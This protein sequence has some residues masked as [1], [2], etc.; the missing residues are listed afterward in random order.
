MQVNSDRLASQVL[1]SIAMRVRIRKCCDTCS[2][3]GVVAI[4][5][6]SCVKENPRS[7]LPGIGFLI[8]MLLGFGAAFGARRVAAIYLGLSDSPSGAIGVVCAIA[9]TMLF[10]WV[11]PLR[12]LICS[13]CRKVKAVGVGRVLPLEWQESI[14][15][16]WKCASCGY[17]LIG[18]NEVARC[19]ECGHSFPDE[20]LKGTCQGTCQ[21]AVVFEIR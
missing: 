14:V 20:W 12:L 16:D 19:P 6:W 15:P 8:G 11:V 1:A 17:N 3:H 9:A 2:N 13:K 18:V 10:L 7:A 5:L 21:P 4:G